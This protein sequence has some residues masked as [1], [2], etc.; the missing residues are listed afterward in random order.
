MAMNTLQLKYFFALSKYRNYSETAR[1]LY[2]AQPAISKQ[3]A[4][5]ETELNIRLFTRTKRS[6]D[7][8]EEGKIMLNALEKIYIIF[9]KAK[10]NALQIKA[11]STKF[12]IAFIQGLDIGVQISPALKLLK[13][14]CPNVTI[15]VDCLNHD[16][17]NEALL[18]NELD[19]VITLEQEV[20]NDKLLDFIPLCHIKQAIAVRSVHPLAQKADIDLNLLRQQIFFATSAGSRG[21]KQYC[22]LLNDHFNIK[23]DS[24]AEVPDI[25]TLLLNVES[26]LGV[27]L[28]SETPRLISNKN[29]KLFSIDSLP[30]LGIVAAWKHNNCN[31]AIN[32]LINILKTRNDKS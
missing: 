11:T 29:V 23:L 14:Q 27:A 2:V 26:G 13:L 31:P 8:T 25:E 16:Q 15:T 30:P 5:L 12:R 21:F 20:L 17:L 19:V 28:L 1:H 18:K 9:E 4:A 6:V 22:Q 10:K 32:S 24:I 3:I 7:L